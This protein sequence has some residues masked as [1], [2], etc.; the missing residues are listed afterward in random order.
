MELRD[1][2]PTTSQE[3]SHQSPHE[4][5]QETPHETSQGISQAAPQ[6][7]RVERITRRAIE[8]A[9]DEAGVAPATVSLQTHFVND[10]QF[11]SLA[12]VEYAMALED[13][14]ELSIDD[15]ELD[16]LQTIGDVVTFIERQPSEAKA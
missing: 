12:R 1:T 3:T 16:K 4:T 2:S 5:S 14:F 6:E 7:M 15:T 10:L 13:E 8:L 11:D 9:A